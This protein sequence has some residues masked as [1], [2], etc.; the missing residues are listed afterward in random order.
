MPVS[1][2][3]GG[4]ADR[5][6]AGV[7]ARAVLALQPAVPEGDAVAIGAESVVSFE[8]RLPDAPKE[9]ARARQ[10]RLAIVRTAQAEGE[11]QR[12]ERLNAE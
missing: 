8:D 7:R 4:A 1:V 5:I 12:V 11:S 3:V 6:A 2:R 10:P 9:I